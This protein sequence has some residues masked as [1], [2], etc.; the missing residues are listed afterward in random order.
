MINKDKIRLF[1]KED[2]FPQEGFRKNKK[3]LEDNGIV[4]GVDLVKKC[5]EII[6]D[7]KLKTEVLA[8]SIRNS[9][10]FREVAE[11]GAD[12]VTVPFEV[13]KKLWQNTKNSVSLV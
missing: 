6:K 2:Y 11:A 13:I 1:K 7:S 9:R 3:V 12:I 8:A 4:S 5:V 10:Q